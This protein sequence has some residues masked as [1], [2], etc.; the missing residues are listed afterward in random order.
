MLIDLEEE[1]EYIGPKTLEKFSKY[2]IF[3][4]YWYPKRKLYLA[5][6]CHKDPK[7]ECE[8]FEYA[9]SLYIKVHYIYFEE[10]SL[11]EKYEN[12]INKVEHN[13][14]LTDT[15]ALDIAFTSKFISKKDAPEV[16]EKLCE[17][18]RD[19]QIEDKGLRLDVK[20][21]LGGMI[22]KHV[23]NQSKQKRLMEVIG[24]REIKNELDELLYEEY[25]DK[26]DA[27]DKEI[28]NLKKSNEKYK[29]SNQE[30]KKS[31]EKYK[32]QIEKLN[33]LDDLN[34]PEARKILSSLKLL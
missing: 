26:L 29:R 5:V 8:C 12:I 31:N 9:P 22:L 21:I 28:N 23:Q 30:Y 20:V 6:I 16:I 4:C 27:K 17:A 10:D 25:G 2:A 11:W 7:K 32:K 14:T 24:M 18:F 33:E 15:E 1:S 34:T 19:A 3:L 13:E